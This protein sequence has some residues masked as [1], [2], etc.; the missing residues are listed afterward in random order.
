MTEPVGD[1]VDQRLVATAQLEDPPDDLD[2]R[3]LVRAADVVHLARLAAV[4]RGRD[5]RREVL[6]EQPVADVEAV[7]I[8][9]QPVAGERIQHHQRDQLLGVLVWPIVVRAAADDRLEPKRLVVGADEQVRAGLR[10]AVGRRGV[11]RRGLGEGALLDRAV[12]LVGRDL[13][14]A[15]PVL[16]GRLEQ[17][18]RAER[19]G[20][21]ERV[22][23]GDR[24]IDVRLGGEVDDR[25]G[26]RDCAG[27]SGRILDRPLEE[28]EARVVLDVAEILVAPGVGQLVEDDDLVLARA[29]SHAHEVRADEAGAAADEE[30]HASAARSAR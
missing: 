7:A 16:A 15:Q 19:V 30:P 23:L 13:D 18:E 5:R 6:D 17:D 22:G 20:P 3:A 27:N 12:D 4:E 21:H 29:Q 25:V 8:D 1:V 28:R 11:E 14:V 9:R 26:A 24:A 2:V 10:R